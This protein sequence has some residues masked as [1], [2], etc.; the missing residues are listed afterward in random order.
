MSVIGFTWIIFFSAIPLVTMA[1]PL[2]YIFFKN[3]VG[4]IEINP[5]NFYK[6]AYI[7]NINLI[8]IQAK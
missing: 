8:N 5:S 3:N 1:K 6:I 4:K 2:L 7:I